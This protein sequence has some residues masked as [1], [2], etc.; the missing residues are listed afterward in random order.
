MNT[1][2]TL[3]ITGILLIVTLMLV[4]LPTIVAQDD[5]LPDLVLAERKNFFPEGI[6]WDAENEHFLLG[7]MTEGTVFALQDD[8]TL[9]PFVEDTDL[10]GSGGIQVDAERDRLLVINTNPAVLSDPEEMGFG[11]LG[12]YDLNTGERLQYVDLTDLLTE[13]KHSPNDVAVDAD[14][15]AYVTETLA[16]MLYKVDLEG[17]ASVFLKD[18]RLNLEMIG[19]LPFPIGLNGIVYHPDGYLLVAHLGSGSLIK[20]PLDDP[21]NLTIVQLDEPFGADGM[22]L[23][24]DGEL[25]AS[26][27]TFDAEGN[28]QNDVI[29]VRSNDDWISASIVDRVN[30]SDNP[31]ATLALR[32]D[33][34]YGIATHIMAM[35]SG[36]D[37]EAYEVYRISFENE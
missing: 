18:D 26:A 23:R 37:V 17:N 22:V 33:A 30:V 12:I 34:V 32:D 10:L 27:Y 15:N 25:V 31:P 24:P 28:P 21:D 5:P 3:R 20:V 11:A 36:Q 4:L 2:R 13:G 19:L 29:V 14:G 9:T 1:R 16:P 6:E 7:S 8:G 35:L